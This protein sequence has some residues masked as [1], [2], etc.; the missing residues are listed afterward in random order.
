MGTVS[1]MM[2]CRADELPRQFIA[3]EW[4]A[5]SMNSKEPFGLDG[6]CAKVCASVFRFFLY[7]F[8]EI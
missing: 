3:A 6:V 5:V 2:N 4:T 1:L 8:I 7:F